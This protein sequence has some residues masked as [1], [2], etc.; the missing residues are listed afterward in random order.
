L[1]LAA[2]SALSQVSVNPRSIDFGER[3]QNEQCEA[4]VVIQNT[5][6]KPLAIRRIDKSCDCI[7]VTPAKIAT[8]LA[9]GG[10]QQVRV[11]MSSGRA[12]GRLDKWITI[13]AGDDLRSQVR[14]PIAM[15]V[16][17][18]LEMDPREVVLEGVTGAK[19]V[20]ATVDVKARRSRDSAV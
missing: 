16:F 14:V 18:D 10:S 19:P 4:T 17:E 13:A 8:T 2:G 20:V 15:R 12:M 7:T 6:T 11:T 9:P 5:G 1:V 3:G